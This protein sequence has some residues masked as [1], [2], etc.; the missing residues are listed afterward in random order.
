MNV[1]E[2]RNACIGRASGGMHVI[3]EHGHGTAD[4]VGIVLLQ[5]LKQ[6]RDVTVYTIAAL[7]R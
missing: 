5:R 7:R 3:S 1:A 6:G 4:R 2:M